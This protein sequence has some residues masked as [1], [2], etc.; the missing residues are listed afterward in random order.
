MYTAKLV[1]KTLNNGNL[2]VDVEFTNGVNVLTETCRPSDETGLNHWVASRLKTL[3]A[4]EEIAAKYAEGVT[5]DPNPVVTP[6][7]PTAAEIARN[8]WLANYHKW[9]RVKLYLIDTGLF[10]GNEAKATAL[11]AKVI[12]DFRPEYFDYI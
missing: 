10:T 12:D 4:G 6:P 2:S 3:N 9:T 5:I 8:E 1:G 11:K 7:A